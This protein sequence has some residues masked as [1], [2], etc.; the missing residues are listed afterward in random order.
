MTDNK[1]ASGKLPISYESGNFF[2]ETNGN[3]KNRYFT[4]DNETQNEK[5]NDKGLFELKKRIKQLVKNESYLET[6]L[7][8][9]K[10]VTEGFHRLLAAYAPLIIHSKSD[11]LSSIST[12]YDHWFLQINLNCG[13]YILDGTYRQFFEG[14]HE[15]IKSNQKRLLMPKYF[16]GNM[17]DLYRLFNTNRNLLLPVF[18]KNLNKNQN[19][20]VIEKFHITDLINELYGRSLK[21]P[22]IFSG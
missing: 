19:I 3:P 2:S 18:L 1:K 7:P 14:S 12:G 22:E 6:N 17:K 10:L 8:R 21:P 15:D 16:F 11:M 13:A 5:C 4:E 9:C 20:S